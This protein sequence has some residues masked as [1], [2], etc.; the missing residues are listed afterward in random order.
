MYDPLLTEGLAQSV[1]TLDP[2]SANVLALKGGAG[3]FLAEV[4]TRQLGAN[5]SGLCAASGVYARLHTHPRRHCV[6]SV[7]SRQCKVN[8]RLE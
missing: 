3:E 1:A 6:P 2:T 8:E 7:K 4:I 5:Q